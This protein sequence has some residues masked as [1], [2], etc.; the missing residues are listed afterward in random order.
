MPVV[1]R[2]TSDTQY[3]SGLHSGSTEITYISQQAADGAA[4]A[5][6]YSTASFF[7]D[8]RSAFAEVHKRLVCK[9]FESKG[10][11]IRAPKE[12]GV[13]DTL[14][15][16][17]ASEV[18]NTGFWRIHGASPHLEELITDFLHN[19]FAT[20]DGTPGGARVRR[21]C[22]GAGPPLADVLFS[23]AFIT[24]PTCSSRW[25]TKP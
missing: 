7:F 18:A 12:Q 15:R 9:D 24:R 6:G 4:E 21:G 22:A 5:H 17:I 19:K 1:N 20:F 25:V 3:G 14:A 11:L 16:E 2:A 23:I 8:I 13:E 10:K